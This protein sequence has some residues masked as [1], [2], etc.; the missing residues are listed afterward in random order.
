VKSAAE[1]TGI[2]AILVSW[3]VIRFVLAELDYMLIERHG[4]ERQIVDVLSFDQRHFRA[5]RGPSGRPF[6][7]LPDDYPAWGPPRSGQ[8]RLTPSSVRRQCGLWATSQ[9]WP[10]G[11]TKTPL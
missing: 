5:V 4:Q 8:F 3:P 6:R 10:S 7:L 2:V 1:A 11:S 9:G